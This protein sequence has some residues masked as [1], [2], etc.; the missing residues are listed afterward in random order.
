MVTM[1]NYDNKKID[2]I[3][4][5]KK[6]GTMIP[7]KFRVIDDDGLL[8]E[9]RIRAYRDLSYKGPYEMPNGIIATST[10]FPFECKIDCFGREKVLLLYYNCDQH[11]W[12]LSSKGRG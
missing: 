5:H 9:Y 12:T 2:M 4:E 10:I 1:D 11:V 7:I 8:H 3:C 6:D